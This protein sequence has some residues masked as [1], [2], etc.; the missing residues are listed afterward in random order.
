MPMTPLPPVLRQVEQLVKEHLALRDEPLL[1]A[2]YFEPDRNPGDIFLFEVIEG[3][4]AGR[5][6]E[7]GKFFEVSYGS[8]PAFPLSPGQRLHLVLTNP[9][10]LEVASRDNWQSL[11]EI[12]QSIKDGRATTLFAEPGRPDL[13]AKLSG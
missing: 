9:E 13:E 12:R 6:D 4:G 2:I 10:E 7:D 11:A 1:L 3:F 5:I 8:T